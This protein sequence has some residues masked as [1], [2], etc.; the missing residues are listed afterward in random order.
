MRISILL[1]TLCFLQLAHH[2]TACELKTRCRYVAVLS[3]S[4][5]LF[6]IQVHLFRRF[7]TIVKSDCLLRHCMKSS[8][9][10]SSVNILKCSNVSG[11]NSVGTLEHFN[12]LTRL[13]A[14]EDFIEF[15][16]HKTSTHVASSCL[17]VLRISVCLSACPSAWNSLA[18]TG[19]IL[20]KFHI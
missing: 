7:L 5:L 4:L 8:R 14:R 17:S 20:M 1:H 6:V 13:L 16:R 19:R 18:S 15:S 3:G 9:A 2:K 11:T 10:N 12:I